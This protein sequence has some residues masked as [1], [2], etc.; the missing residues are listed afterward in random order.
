M[1]TCIDSLA[2]TYLFI[3]ACSSF[4]KLLYSS[5]NAKLSGGLGTVPKQDLLRCTYSTH[6]TRDCGERELA[7]TVAGTHQ[8]H[9]EVIMQLHS[10][11]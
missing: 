4:D 11:H 7:L 5:D 8:G 6:T 2:I 1:F 10:D 9:L 3:T